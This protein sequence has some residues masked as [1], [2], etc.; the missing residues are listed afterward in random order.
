MRTTFEGNNF[1]VN[2]RAI[3]FRLSLTLGQG[4]LV[5]REFHIQYQVVMR[6]EN[7]GGISHISDLR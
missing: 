5:R 7:T 1:S 2:I 6:D 4:C 3:N